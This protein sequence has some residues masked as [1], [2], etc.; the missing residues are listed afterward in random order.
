M[1]YQFEIYPPWFEHNMAF[2]IDPIFALTPTWRGEHENCLPGRE[3]RA[4]GANGGERV[5]GRRG[6]DALG[7][8]FLPQ[9]LHDTRVAIVC[10][11]TTMS[12]TMF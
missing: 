3:A 12:T 8:H 11:S 6:F 5:A 4:E 1:Q 7:N 2:A 10:R 9:L